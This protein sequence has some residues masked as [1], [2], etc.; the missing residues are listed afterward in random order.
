MSTEH[1]EKQDARISANAEAIKANAEAI[2]R[3]T[4]YLHEIRNYFIPE[5]IIPPAKKKSR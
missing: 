5:E 3:Q 4:E 2:R 1:D